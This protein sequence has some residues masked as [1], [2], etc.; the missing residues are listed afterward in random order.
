MKLPIENKSAMPIYVAGVM[1]PPGETRHFDD[2]QIPPEYRQA[3]PVLEALPVDPL[4][5]LL[6]ENVAVVVGELDGL[7]DDELV[8]L[9][10]LELARKKRKGVLEGIAAEQLIRAEQKAN[11]VDPLAEDGEV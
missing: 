10:G 8:R 7:P 5:T 6:D 1:I 4:N 3:A 11:T 9:E 2:A